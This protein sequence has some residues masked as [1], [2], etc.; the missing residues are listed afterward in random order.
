MLRPQ[1]IVLGSVGLGAPSLKELCPAVSPP[2]PLSLPS[3]PP[4]Q[5]GTNFQSYGGVTKVEKSPRAPSLSHR[6]E[7]ATKGGSVENGKLTLFSTRP[8]FF[9]S[10]ARLSGPSGNHM[11]NKYPDGIE[12]S[13]N[14]IRK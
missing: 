8:F 1:W 5:S 3:F 13:D 14:V 12:N 6:P 4:S 11:Q 2:P 7:N 10:Q 9:A